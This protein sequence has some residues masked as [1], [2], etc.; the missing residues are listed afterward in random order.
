MNMMDPNHKIASVLI[1]KAPMTKEVGPA[2]DDVHEDAAEM[3]VVKEVM[4]AFKENKPE[5][6]KRALMLLIKMCY[7]NYEEQEDRESDET[8][9]SM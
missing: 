7:D 2:F 3:E 5:K 8:P 6:A 4:S 1:G 9:D